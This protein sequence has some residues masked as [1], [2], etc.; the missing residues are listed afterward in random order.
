MARH[1]TQGFSCKRNS[2]LDSFL[3]RNLEQRVYERVRACK[4]CVVISETFK[5]VFIEWQQ[6]LQCSIITSEKHKDQK[7]CN[8]LCTKSAVWFLL[9]GA[10]RRA[11]D[12]EGRGAQGRSGGE[13][14]EGVKGGVEGGEESGGS[15]VY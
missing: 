9:S 2:K 6:T 13:G 12:G 10:Q 14:T 11:R 3:K 1:D 5:K 4:A 15:R 8:E 7:A